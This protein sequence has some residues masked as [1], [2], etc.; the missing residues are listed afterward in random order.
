MSN[1][2]FKIKGQIIDLFNRT[3]FS[4]EIVVEDGHISQII[5][6]NN[7]PN[8]FILPGLID[9]HVHIE[10]SMLIPS[11]FAEMIVPR[12]TIAVVSDPHEI[13]NVMGEE[14]IQFMIDDGKTVPL[15]FFFGAP[16]CVP[17]TS[18][19]SSG[20]ILNAEATEKLLDNP[21]IYFLSEMMNYPGVVSGDKDVMAKI[22]AARKRN[23]KIDG[24][25]PGLSGEDLQKYI[26]AGISTDHECFSLNEAK[27]KIALGMKIQIREGSAARNFEALAPLFQTNP[28][29]VMLCTDDSHPDEIEKSGHIDRLIKLGLKHEINIF[30]LLRSATVIPVQHY[31][32]PVGLLRINDPAD[33][34]VIDSLENFNILESYIN[35]EL[36][37]NNHQGIKFSIPEIK[38]INRFRNNIISSDDTIATL[39]KNKESVKVI[40]IHDGELVT[41]KLLWKPDI[42]ENRIIN[43]DIPKDILKIVVVN[44]YENTPP[45]VGFVK[46]MGIKQGALASSV[47]HDSHN[48]IAIGVDDNSICEALN[49]LIR[50]QGGICAVDNNSSLLLEL[51]VAGLM[52]AQNGKSVSKQYQLLND[53]VHNMGSKLKAPFMA[54]SFLSL[55][56]IPHLKL[57][58][59]GLFDVDK[60]SFTSLFE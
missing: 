18:F 6:L 19:E 33:F 28:E 1:Q 39:P 44:R 26:S 31:N 27:E 23:M 41:S 7:A 36:V 54:L 58:D 30:D 42:C 37:Y 43:S 20:A 60:F 2:N 55:L 21:D 45:A 13:A 15:K 57:G 56:V 29:S 24:H 25:A 59:K 32:L 22:D 48:L 34:I 52:S 5:K 47:A 40:E 16:S 14:G 11:R 4:G 3:I 12:G 50:H 10:S 49:L 17:A 51:P 8:Q 35:G 9:S 46:N 38:P 53:K